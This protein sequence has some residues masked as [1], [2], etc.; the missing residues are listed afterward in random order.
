MNVHIAG[1][2]LTPTRGGGITMTVAV[3]SR[4]DAPPWRAAVHVAGRQGAALVGWLLHLYASLSLT[5]RV[6]NV[7]NVQM[8]DAGSLGGRIL[9]AA[10]G[11]R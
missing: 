9:G 10:L 3:S 7:Q 8:L 2:V 11:R 1:S 4:G 6:Q 5:W